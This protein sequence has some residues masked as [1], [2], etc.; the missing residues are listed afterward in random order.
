M[1]RNE[2]GGSRREGGTGAIGGWRAAR[3]RARRG[4][5]SSLL[6]GLGGLVASGALVAGMVGPA[7]AGASKTTQ[8]GTSH[9]KAPT[10]TR[11]KTGGS[12]TV[13]EWSGY[14]GSWPGLD[15]AT[16][17]N[18]A[19]DQS[20]MDAIFGQ[21]F[22]L[23]PGGKIIPDLAT[24]YRFTN[25]GK[26]IV[27]TLRKGVVFSDGTP[28][29]AQAVVWN[30]E[31]DL[32]S[33]CTC[34]PTFNQKARPTIKAV[35]AYQVSI[36]LDYVDAAFINALQ[37]DI[38][39]WIVSPTAFKKEKE[40]AFA[41]KPVGAGPFEVV[42][43][44][45]SSVLVLKR[46]PHYWQ[47]GHP[48]LDSLTFKAVANDQAALEA[49]DSG[50]GQAYEDMSTP[51]LV[52]AFKARFEVT[53]EPATSPYDIQL[54]TAIPPF[55]NL[56]ARQA[57]YYATNCQLL[58]SRLFSDQSPC[59]ESFT[60]PAGLFYEQKVPGYLTYDL[61]KAR[62]LV[63][64]LGG[65][66]VKLFTIQNPD[67]LNMIEALQTMWQQAGMKV[68]I[69]EYDLSTLIG[70]FTSGK[71]QAALQT[72]GAYD[73]ATGVGVAFRFASTSPFSG[74]HDPHLDA[75]LNAAAGT[76]DPAA[77]KRFYD[78]AAAY[79]AEKA[80][81]PFLFP[82]NG[83]DVADKGVQ[84]PGLSTPLPSVAVTPAIL[85]EDVSNSNR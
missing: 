40:A 18:G 69:A 17:T 71:W 63:K 83:Y 78:E 82:I 80:Y 43:D 10:T 15:P 4:G 70:Q 59:G 72:A 23:G 75:L 36:S 61:A 47:A 14:A 30:W 56:K 9:R 1:D 68:S 39:N 74:V 3:S 37:D 46:N 28:F 41:L 31:R 67:A 20:Y 55:N 6:A 44:T 52:K 76:I 51:G 81:G 84:G 33:T 85:W 29:N 57:I 32:S 53:S 34:K 49:M 65:L 16:D 11:I 8:R 77:R 24:A 66:D 60:A 48:Y 19:A 62:K 50:S 79:I 38:F 64:E 54:N 5:R 27:I 22:E 58:D 7:V 2:I 21:L 13:L 12:L 45:P 35:G 25:T 42:S 73:P 26:T